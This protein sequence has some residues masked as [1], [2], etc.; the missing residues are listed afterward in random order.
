MLSN[1]IEVVVGGQTCAN[2]EVLVGKL[3]CTYVCMSAYVW[4]RQVSA[5]LCAYVCMYVHDE[6]EVDRETMAVQ[7]CVR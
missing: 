1:A 4:C 2:L 7:R 5:C 6:C 3:Y